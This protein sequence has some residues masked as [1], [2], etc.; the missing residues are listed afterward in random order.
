MSREIPAG[1]LVQEASEAVRFVQGGGSGS[2]IL[3]IRAS[4]SETRRLLQQLYQTRTDV[5]PAQT[6]HVLKAK[7]PGRSGCASP[8]RQTSGEGGEGGAQLQPQQRDLD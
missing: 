7:A 5:T 1:F 8:G 4:S 6:L 2:S 3:S